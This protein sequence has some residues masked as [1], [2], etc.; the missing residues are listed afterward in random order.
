MSTKQRLVHLLSS[1]ARRSG[2]RTLIAVSPVTEWVW[3]RTRALALGPTTAASQETAAI[4]ATETPGTQAAAPAPS[5]LTPPIGVAFER[6]KFR[7]ALKARYERLNLSPE[8]TELYSGFALST[9]ERGEQL[10]Q[11]LSA[12]TDITGKRYLDVG[13][14]YG[15]FPVAFHAAGAR[16]VVG[17]DY[18]PEL[19]GYAHALR[20]DYGHPLRLEQ[21]SILSEALPER[22]GRFD[23]ITCNDVIEHVSDPGL[24]LEHLAGLLNPGGLLCMEIPN[25]WSADFV[26]RDGHFYKYALTSLPKYLADRRF[27]RETQ[28]GV[29]DVTYKSLNWYLHRLRRAGL[30][31]SVDLGGASDPSATLARASA[32]FDEV[33]WKARAPETDA[34]SARY[35]RRVAATFRTAHGRWRGTGAASDETARRLE[36][37]F[38]T[39]FWTLI[40]TAPSA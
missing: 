14:A 16:E 30:N 39:N 25:R 26:L 40:A 34:L 32:T 7:A 33:E 37:T 23:I 5:L 22:F 21:A 2:L 1:A 18:D 17:F 35:A 9:V 27:S 3:R 38:A 8:I 4:T 10:R 24:A 36:I 6:P 12:H 28:G 31:A 13:C 15:G 20:E 29:H 19:L 11:K